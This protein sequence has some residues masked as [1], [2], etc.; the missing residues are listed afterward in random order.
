MIWL[1]I[2]VEEITDMNFNIRWKQTPEINYA[3][4]IDSFIEFSKGHKSTAF[5]LGSFAKKYPELVKKLS[6]NDIEI[7]CHGY[8]HELVYKQSFEQW[9]EQLA[10]A[11]SLLEEITS[12]QVTGYRSPSWSMPFEKK[13]YTEL[14]RLGFSYSSSYFPMKNYMYGNS[15][16]KKE[17]FDIH[18]TS[19]I[20]QE[21]P[22][23]KNIIPFSGGFYLRVLPLWLLKILFKNRSNSIL[24]IHPYEL[25]TKNLLLLLRKYA[26]FN[27]DY[28]LA[29]YSTGYAKNKIISILNDE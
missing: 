23:V 2:D 6:D 16:N 3:K 7:A 13:Y 24:Y 20:V 21:R 25:E 12:K 4:H 1:T 29:F 5:I 8:Y 10:E 28:I 18:T 26:G 19:G 22:I 9:S 17:F 11:K 14:A 27:L 15:I